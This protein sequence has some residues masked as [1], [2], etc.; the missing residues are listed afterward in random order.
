MNINNELRIEK[1]LELLECSSNPSEAWQKV[2]KRFPGQ[3]GS[4]FTKHEVAEYVREHNIKVSEKVSDII[5]MKPTRTLSGIAPITIFTKPYTCSGNCI[6]C[7]SIEGMPK[8]YLPEEPAMQRAIIQ[9]FDPYRQISRRLESFKL[10]GHDTSKIEII[11]SGGTWDDYPEDYRIWYIC[12]VFRAL[13]QDLS[14]GIPDIDSSKNTVAEANYEKLV[15]LQQIN[16]TAKHR[17]VGMS[18]ETRPDK[19]TVESVCQMRK[20]GVTKVQIGVQSLNDEVLK[21]NCRGHNVQTT[22]DALNLLRNNGFKIQI[23]W[24]AN[25]YGSDLEKDLVDFKKLFNSPS[26]L[27]DEIKIYPCSIVENTPLHRLFE[28]GKF[29]P[30]ST[31]ELIELLAKCKVE[32]EPY[33]RVSRLFRDIP[34]GSIVEGNK[35]TNLR[36]MVQGYMRAQGTKCKCIRCNE[37]KSS[38]VVLD[39]LKLN[40]YE[41]KSSTSKEFYITYRNA[42][43]QIA[44]FLRLSVYFDRADMSKRI[45]DVDSMIR[46]VHVY[47]K[48]VN[49]GGKSDG[50]SQHIGLGTRLIRKAEEIALDNGAKKIAVISAVG[51]R[52]YYKNLGYEIDKEFGYGVKKVISSK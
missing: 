32:I 19:V 10:N 38:K 44:G 15:N 47:G 14:S 42:D 52:E 22:F 45:I 9:E 11:V 28:K 8:S 49:V 36:E 7:P 51:T 24:M 50:A 21:L 23:H 33:C 35:K 25:L 48:V 29:I 18:I 3:S 30:Y 16:S 43:D 27:P 5:K 37:V 40:V 41:Y 2:T 46:E 4:L 34:S 31:Q 26:V 12:E 6:Y 1:V 13:N 39:E 17:C 20:Y